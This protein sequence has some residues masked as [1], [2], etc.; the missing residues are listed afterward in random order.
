MNKKINIYQV[1]EFAEEGNMIL[2]QGTLI[3]GE[4]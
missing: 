2:Y 3:P 4:V 1:D